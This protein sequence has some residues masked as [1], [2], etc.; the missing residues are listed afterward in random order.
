MDTEKWPKLSCL[1]LKLLKGLK[2]EDHRLKVFLD[3]KVSS[4]LP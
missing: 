4:K 2:Q 1:S 3:Y